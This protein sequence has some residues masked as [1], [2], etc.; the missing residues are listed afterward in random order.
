[1]KFQLKTRFS[2]SK[3]V[4]V[5]IAA[6]FEAADWATQF[7]AALKAICAAHT[8]W[9]RGEACGT[10]AVLTRA[11]LTGAVLTGADL[12]RAVLTGADLTDAVLTG[13]DL[14]RADLTGAVLTDADLTR[15]D[16]TGADLTEDVPVIDAINT[17]ILAA[18]EA[19][20]KLRMDKWHTCRTT[21]CMAGWAVVIAGESGTKLEE[22]VGP[23]VAGLL[24][25]R[26]S[27][28]LGIPNF[29]AEDDKAM[30]DLRARAAKEAAE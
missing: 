21:H 4:E 28:K 13:A 6:E 9:R 1:M 20:G 24:I 25:F 11:D 3:P 17:K 19:G 12:T 18:V 7:A 30:A 16:L 22:K 29:F 10:R 23:H 27:S 8:K 2:W 14:T 26:A 5:E 15:A